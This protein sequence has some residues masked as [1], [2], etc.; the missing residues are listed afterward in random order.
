MDDQG[1]LVLPNDAGND[2]TRWLDYAAPVVG[3]AGAFK[4]AQMAGAGRLL[5]A[6]AGGGTGAA[7]LGKDWPWILKLLGG[8][9]V[10]KK[11]GLM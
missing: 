4:L 7:V 5:S 8:E 6:V 3:P 10:A 9:M 2:I 1:R 11:L